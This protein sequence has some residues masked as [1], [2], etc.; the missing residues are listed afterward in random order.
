[1]SRRLAPGVGSR[2]D[3][4]TSQEDVQRGLLDGPE[5]GASDLTGVHLS[6]HLDKLCV[7]GLL[8]RLKAP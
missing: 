5:S 1:M 3:G 7:S 8:P 6:F 2:G 4:R